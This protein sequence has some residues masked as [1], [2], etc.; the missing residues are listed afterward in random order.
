MHAAQEV[1]Y[2]QFTGDHA[3][4]MRQMVSLAREEAYYNQRDAARANDADH[5]PSWKAWWM[6]WCRP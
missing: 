1:P 4:F 2:G 5:S 6:Q 3:F